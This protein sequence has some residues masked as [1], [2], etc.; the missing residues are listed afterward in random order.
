MLSPPCPNPYLKQLKLVLIVYIL[1]SHQSAALL[2]WAQSDMLHWA[3]CSSDI[4][5]PFGDG[6]YSTSLL[7]GYLSLMWSFSST[8]V[9]LPLM[10]K[11]SL[12]WAVGTSLVHLNQ[13]LLPNLSGLQV[14]PWLGEPGK[15]EWQLVNNGTEGRDVEKWERE[16]CP[17]LQ[18]PTVSLVSC[19]IC[20]WIWL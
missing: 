19:F 9:Y 14:G 5:C 4:R 15:L 17:S 8:V 2:L 20:F 6:I 16:S 7:S 12:H 13:V 10:S 18:L 11:N 1:N 3:F